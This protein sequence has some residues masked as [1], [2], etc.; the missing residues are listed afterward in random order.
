[1]PI[2]EQAADVA[3]NAFLHHKPE[4]GEWFTG[5]VKEANLTALIQYI[6]KEWGQGS[7]AE[8]SSSTWEIAFR[9]VKA[10]GSLI[11]DPNYISEANKRRLD[12]MSTAEVRSAVR[13]EPGFNELWRRYSAA[14]VPL[15]SITNDPYVLLDAAGYAAIP[16]VER[17]RLY[18]QDLMFR[19]ATERLIQQGV[20]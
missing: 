19:K 4:A 18:A 12:R 1:M 15:E 11:S 20:I 16:P 2:D 17:A 3:F 13:S 7:R 14:T 10:A 5:S 6:V 9:A 8:E